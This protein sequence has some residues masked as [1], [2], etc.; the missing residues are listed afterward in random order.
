MMM[1][2]VESGEEERFDLQMTMLGGKIE[3]SATQP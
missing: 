2:G 1:R 3:F